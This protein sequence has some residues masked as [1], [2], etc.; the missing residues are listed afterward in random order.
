MELKYN[1]ITIRNAR[2][3]DTINNYGGSITV[4]DTIDLQLA[5]KP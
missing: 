2:I 3:E 5:R 1:G 4:F